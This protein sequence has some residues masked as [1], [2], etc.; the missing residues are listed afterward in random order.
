MIAEIIEKEKVQRAKE[1]IANGTKFVIVAHVSPDGD[2]VGSSLALAHFLKGCGKDSVSVVYPNEFPLFYKWMPGAEDAVIFEKHEKFAS[3]LV[4][5]ADVI[6]AM[7]FNEIKRLEKLAPVVEQSQAK[8]ILIDHHLNP[9][10]FCE[11]VM[12]YP[13]MSSTCELLYRFISQLGK[14]NRISRDCA[15]C[16]YAGMMTDTGSF[17]FNSNRSEIY[18]IV[19]ELIRLGIDKDKIY[20]L[21]NQVYSENRLRMMG[22]IL[23]EKMKIY[24]D[25]HAALMTLS[26]EE[27]N[28][29]HYVTGDTETFV[30]LPL[31]IDGV[32]FSCFI[33]EDPDY[34]KISLRS[35]GDFP[36]QIFA[37]RY[38]NGGGHKNASGGEFYGSLQE[39]IDLFEKALK[40][41]EYKVE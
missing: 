40:E 22:Y 12:S 2:A 25:Y 32:G 30:N 27:L 21:V 16:L 23:Y 11:V 38:F 36:C 28:R 33:R 39:A 1:I 8:K 24:P 7:D 5:E 6:F 29:F 37:K 34:I 3:K 4:G 13:T 31:S 17:T 14:T 41:F 19:G 26:K 9:S 35:V 18:T 20:R 10:D 15:E